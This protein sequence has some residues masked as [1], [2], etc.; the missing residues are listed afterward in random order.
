MSSKA[1][2]LGS[3]ADVYQSE[4]LDGAITKIRLESLIPSEVQPRWNRTQSVDEL[5][6]SIAKDGLLSP[7]IVC[8]E[9]D[10][11]R[12]IAG[13]RRYHAIK[14]LNYL[15]I[16]CRIISRQEKDYWRIAIIENLQRENL[17]PWEEANALSQLKKNENLNDTEI[18]KL[19]GKSR[20]YVVEILSLS[21]LPEEIVESCKNMGLQQRNMLIEV[22]RAYKKG[23]IENFL[24]AYRT[25]QITTVKKAK[26][27]RQSSIAPTNKKLQT[28]KTKQQFKLIEKMSD[29]EIWASEF[30]ISIRCKNENSKDQLL[31]ILQNSNI[32]KK[33]EN[34]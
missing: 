18:G 1:N 12:I 26:K 33:I 21:V 19:I 2:I 22:T 31:G 30:Q 8:K 7:I 20:N 15:D 13:E 28:K 11:Y 32:F 25:G 23:E 14:K 34:Q 16:E 6:Q 9:G 5:A 17:F 27:F 29:C 24:E 3:L 10:L 4:N